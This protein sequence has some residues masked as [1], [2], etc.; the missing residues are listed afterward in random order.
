MKTENP[1]NDRKKPKPA[2]FMTV[3]ALAAC[4]III[5]FPLIV[6]DILMAVNVILSVVML[7]FAIFSGGRRRS[8]DLSGKADNPHCFPKALLI[9]TLFGVMVN[10][11]SGRPIL[12][13]GAGFDSLVIGFVAGLISTSGT[14]GIIAAFIGFIAGVCFLM[15]F[16]KGLNRVYE[17]AARFTLDAIPGKAMAVEALYNG[18]AI[19]EE[20]SIVQKNSLQE[21]ADFLGAMDGALKFV[22]GAPK[23]AICIT[24]AIVLHGVIAGTN[25]EGQTIQEAVAISI[26]LAIA[27]GLVFFLPLLLL[28]AAAYKLW[29]VSR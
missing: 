21:E 18:G 1:E 22:T 28:S 16:I 9:C 19:S 13:Q 17:V 10:I 7:L 8:R 2:G 11:S 6:L 5:P 27:H 15:L 26:S 12:I 4:V 29:G 24:T 23:V 14:A 20:D 3:M 25:F